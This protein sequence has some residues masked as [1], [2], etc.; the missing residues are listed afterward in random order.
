LRRHDLCPSHA[1]VENGHAEC[2]WVWKRERLQEW[3]IHLTINGQPYR[4]KLDVRTSLLDL[5]REEFVEA[6]GAKGLG[7][8][9]FRNR[10]E[11]AV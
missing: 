5:L 3:E 10:S 8:Q 7:A 1:G 2:S 9:T 6:L 11:E 4:L